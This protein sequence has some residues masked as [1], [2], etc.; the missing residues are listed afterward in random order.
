MIQRWLLVAVMAF[1]LTGC[2]TKF[3]YNWL[4]WIIEWEVADYV[5]LDRAQERQ[6]EQ[7]IDELLEWHR[8]Q[9]L[10]KYHAQLTQLRKQL[11]HGLTSEQVLA[12]ATELEQH[13][14]RI[15]AHLLPQ[16]V[17]FIQSLNDAQIAS[18]VAKIEEENKKDIERYLEKPYDER[19]TR[20]NRRMAKSLKRWVGKL[21]PIQQSAVNEFN[22]ERHQSMDLWVAYR[23]A[24]QHR[25]IDALEQRQHTQS[26]EQSLY[27]LLVQ[28][29]SLR[30]EAYKQQLSVN[31]QEFADSIVK[32]QQTL[33]GKQRKRLNRQLGSLLDDLADLSER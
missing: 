33:T 31:Q 8:Y 32:I 16:L 26:L 1:T 30:P 5:E 10:P 22:L 12:H 11:N 19:V 9:E 29:E 4:D 15:F 7:M 3:V 25:F 27:I 13:W 24:W 17:P 6:L 28:P 23:D 20:S 2:S 18:L 14:R 21:T